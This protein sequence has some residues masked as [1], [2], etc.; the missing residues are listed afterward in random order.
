MAALHMSIKRMVQRCHVAT[1]IN[2]SPIDFP[3]IV[4]KAPFCNFRNASHS[5][6]T[7]G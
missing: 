1:Q 6:S 5:C 7:E 2:E 3:N 4:L